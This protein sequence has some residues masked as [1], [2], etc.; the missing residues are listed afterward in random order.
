M[1]MDWPQ[2][3]DFFLPIFLLSELHGYELAQMTPSL[4]PMEILS[5]LYAY[6]LAPNEMEVL[7]ELYVYVPPR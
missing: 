7:S 2:M 6:G 3:T 4:M 5:A 1:V